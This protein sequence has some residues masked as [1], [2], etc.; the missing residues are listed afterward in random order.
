M[1]LRRGDVTGHRLRRQTMENSGHEIECNPLFI[2]Q[3][4]YLN[5]MKL[6]CFA[7]NRRR[8]CH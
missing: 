8:I 5:S 7:T 1:G 3:L 6:G 2:D 4:K